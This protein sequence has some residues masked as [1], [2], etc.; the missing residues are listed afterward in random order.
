MKAEIEEYKKNGNNNGDNKQ[1][2][3]M[4]QKNILLL[5]KLQEAQKKILQANTLVNKAKKYN[6]CIAYV[7]QLLNFFKPGDDKQTYLFN[8]LKSYVEEYE[9]EKATKKHE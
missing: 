5:N 6:I 3:E 9:K 4:K 2:E 8:K 7:S 1:Y